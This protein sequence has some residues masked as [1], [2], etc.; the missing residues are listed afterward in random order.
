MQSVDRALAILSSFGSDRSSL[1]VSELAG[2]IGIHKSTV[3]RM[4]T[5]LERRQFVRRDGERF[6]PGIEIVRIARLA[7]AEEALAA[8]AAA[9]LE[10]LARDTGEAALIGVR[11][12]DEAYFIQQTPGDHILGVADW[13]GRSTLLHVSG[14]GKAL[15]A[16]GEAPYEGPLERFTPR[17]IT[18][19]AAWER[20]LRRIRLR[21]YAVMRDELEPGLSAVA[22]PVLDDRG[23][24][25]AAVAVT[26]PTFRFSRSLQALG[27]RCRT[28]AVEVT[29][30]LGA[31]SS[32]P[33]RPRMTAPGVE[34][35]VSE[36]AH[37]E[38][39]VRTGGV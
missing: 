26:G 5:A 29:T 11:R 25:V 1:R 3:S 6:V 36:G 19:P 20:E 32:L 37:E 8:A 23:D 34:E 18:D 21:G 24:C 9:A 2:E 14:I 22:A 15:V 30:A 39:T 35:E 16:F 33:G 38:R 7:S 4:L 27:E 13:A 31:T 28:A 12:G 10:S 17:T